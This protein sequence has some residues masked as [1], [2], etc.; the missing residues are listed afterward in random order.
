MVEDD[1]LF[2]ISCLAHIRSVVVNYSVIR[3]IIQVANINAYRI[4]LLTSDVI[5]SAYIVNIRLAQPSG[6]EIIPRSCHL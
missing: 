5:Q 4:T 3:D 1:S 2:P 6:L